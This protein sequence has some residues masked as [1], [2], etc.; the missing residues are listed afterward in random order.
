M[1]K[2]LSCW[3]LAGVVLLQTGVALS[4]PA[5]C[6]TTSP[7][8]CS[9]RQIGDFLITM[10]GNPPRIIGLRESTRS[11]YRD[12]AARGKRPRPWAHLPHVLFRGSLDTSGLRVVEV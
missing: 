5:Y 2:R 4:Q 8:A 6:P 9:G 11:Y 3:G 12:C 7:A 10:H 1:S